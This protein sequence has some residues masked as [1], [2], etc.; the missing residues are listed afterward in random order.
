MKITVSPIFSRLPFVFWSVHHVLI[1][2]SNSFE[3]VRAQVDM[4]YWTAQ[5]KEFK[6]DVDATVMCIFP[7]AWPHTD[8]WSC[9]SLPEHIAFAD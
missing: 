7:T 8:Q 6:N 9:I 3:F 1:S 2:R 4:N 5:L